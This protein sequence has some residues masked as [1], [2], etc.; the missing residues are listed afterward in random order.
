MALENSIEH[1]AALMHTL[2]TQE[3]INN[4]FGLITSIKRGLSVILADLA[5]ET[6]GGKLAPDVA[7]RLRRLVS[8]IDDQRS[9]FAI[10]ERWLN[11]EFPWPF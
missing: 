10:P 4:T 6:A 8:D 2:K 9:L 3:V 11:I 5:R 7:D 1:V